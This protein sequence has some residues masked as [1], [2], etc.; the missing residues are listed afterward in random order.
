MSNGVENTHNVSDPSL[1]ED[2]AYL[3]LSITVEGINVLRAI[4]F[5]LLNLSWQH[6]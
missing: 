3:L 4:F 6:N 1:L 5:V 2:F